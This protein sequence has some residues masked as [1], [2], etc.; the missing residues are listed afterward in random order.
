MG[1]VGTEAT[2]GTAGTVDMAATMAVMV[3]TWDGAKARNQ[4]R[5]P[6]LLVPPLLVLNPFPAL[7][8]QVLLPLITSSLKHKNTVFL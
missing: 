5:P 4:D 2:A 7:P 8:L 1:T 6:I 3:D